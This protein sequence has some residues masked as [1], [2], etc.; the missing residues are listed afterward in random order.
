MSIKKTHKGKRRYAKK[1]QEIVK[2][3]EEHIYSLLNQAK[4]VSSKDI[5]LANRYVE[6][7]RKIAM[8]F[9]VRLSSEQKRLFCQHCYKFLVPGKNLRVRVHEHRLI[10]YCLEC[11]RFWRRPVKT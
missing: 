3:A 1:K 10:Y 11:K 8:K 5:E 9:K 4:E 2:T 7:A 6:L